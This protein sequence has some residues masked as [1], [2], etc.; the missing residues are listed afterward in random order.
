MRGERNW[1]A[2]HDEPNKIR[3]PSG[4]STFQKAHAVL[5]KYLLIMECSSGAK[6]CTS[7]NVKDKIR[8]TSEEE[9]DEK[10]L[11][12]VFSTSPV[13]FRLFSHIR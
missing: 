12:I 5:A 8:L 2:D 4:Q 1:P 13:I 3:R 7:D 6:E 9:I 11:I 10:F